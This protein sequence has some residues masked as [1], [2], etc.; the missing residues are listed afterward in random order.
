MYAY[1]SF[2]GLFNDDVSNAEHIDRMIGQLVNNK[3]ERMW[4]GAI[5]A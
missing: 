1:F 2:F 4:K 5:E 3:W